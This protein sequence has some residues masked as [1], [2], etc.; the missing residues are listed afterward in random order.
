MQS[1]TSKVKKTLISHAPA[2]SKV[3]PG[4]PRV[5]QNF[6][7]R[8]QRAS[9]TTRKVISWLAA[10]K[11]RR[12][13]SPFFILANYLDPHHPY[14][15][16]RGYRY[17]YTPRRIPGI[18]WQAISRFNANP[19][20]CMTEAKYFDSN[21]FEVLSALYDAEIYYLDRQLGRLFAYMKR[22]GILDKTLVIL[23]SPHGENLGEH[24]LGGHQA[25]LYEPIIHI[26][27][28]MRCPNVVPTG[29]R[30]QSL[31]QLTDILP[32]VLDLIDFNADNLR[33]QGISLSRMHSNR[34][35][36][37]FAIAEWEGGVP[38]LLEGMPET[39]AL[40][41]AVARCRRA[42]RMLRE[43]DYKYIWAS[44]GRE[45]LFNLADDPKELR[46]LA[47]QEPERVWAMA[48][49][50]KDLQ[51]SY[52]HPTKLVPTHNDVEE[53]ILNDLRALGY[54]I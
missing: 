34:I 3:I 18:D 10:S 27:L 15:A 33:L 19:Y 39:S 8:S 54:R 36:R 46:N 42:L 43:G 25:C 37:D 44:D 13:K 53:T 40:Q 20:L 16:P 24:G 14:E 48:R 21:L 23:L 17:R 11:Q 50:L 47:S 38:A 35:Q 9:F 51:G 1:I 29:M 4:S 31:V 41:F 30:V 32:T 52:T 12:A 45:E 6:Y 2:V 5:I 26:P 28:I 7:R 49:R 22:Q